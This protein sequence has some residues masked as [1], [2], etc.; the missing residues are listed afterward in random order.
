M[1]LGVRY[2]LN[3]VLKEKNNL[4]GNFDPT[5]GLIQDGSGD[6]V[7]ESPSIFVDRERS[8]IYVLYQNNVAV[9]NA[10]GME[11]LSLRL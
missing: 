4:L 8:E 11:Y 5:L 10:S 2:E 9:Y 7:Y 6:I 1:N 3:T